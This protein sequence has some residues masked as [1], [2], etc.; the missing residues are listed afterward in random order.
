MATVDPDQKRI[1]FVHPD[2]GIGG[3]ERLV[4]DAAVGLQSLGHKVTIFTS[5]RD[6]NH[7]FTEARDVAGTLDVRVR[8]DSIFPPTIFGRFA[9]LCAI[10]R[11]VHL[12]LSIAV[13]SYELQSLR[14]TDL[15][16]DQLSAGVPLFRF[17]YSD[18][19]ILFYCHFPD[20]LLSQPGSGFF[21]YVKQAYRLFFDWLESW[22]MGGSDSIV[23]NSRF[24]GI[25]VKEVF[26]TLMAKPIKVVYPCVDTSSVKEDLTKKK[27]L[28][29]DK[30]ILLS[31][32]RFERKKDVA[33]AIKAYAELD[34]QYRQGTRLVVAG[35][36]DTRVNENVQYHKELEKLASSF[37]LR[38]E[39]MK[40]LGSP[41]DVPSDV[42]VL[43]LLSVSDEVK[44][45]LLDTAALLIYTP[46][47]EHFGIVP[48]ESMLNGVPVLAANEGG[49]L[50][51]VVDGETGWLRDV[52]DTAAWTAVM[53][54][55]LQSTKNDPK[56]LLKMGEAGKERVMEKFSKRKMALNL[57]YCLDETRKV[58]REPMVNVL[59]ATAFGATAFAI[60]LGFFGMWLLFYALDNQGKVDD[61]MTKQAER[62]GSKFAQTS[63]PAS[64]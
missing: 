29:P 55:V 30:R 52:K 21:L 33:L 13:F 28:W 25:T 8:G 47:N 53:Q 1:V 26:P 42:S 38:H 58:R 16:L 35:G 7:C 64:I 43:F 36:Y 56:A 27:S 61:F 39:T 63:V 3:A 34:P 46:R 62:F 45:S 51:T 41:S 5:H 12:I 32:N 59:M 60:P 19:R 23:V 50:E 37:S 14:P 57:N 6:R 48:L 54:N 2:L 22:S 11:Q 10:A 17:L 24:T 40:K 20:K 9:I 18:A 31:I 49:P 4:I 15:F 44:Q